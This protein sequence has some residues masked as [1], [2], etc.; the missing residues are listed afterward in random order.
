MSGGVMAV[1]ALQGMVFAVW[2][3]YAFRC[4]FKLRADAVAAS[5]KL[6]PGPIASIRAFKG[7]VTMPKYGRD[8][9]IM[10]ALTVALFVL[11]GV[12]AALAPVAVAR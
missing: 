6:W 11:I 5:G 9:R 3:F 7:F 10:L 12:F 1:L 2:A 8:R 4:L